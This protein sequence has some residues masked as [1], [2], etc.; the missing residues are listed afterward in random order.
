MDDHA[1]VEALRARDPQAPA[2]LYDAY[3]GGLYGYCWF[4]LCDRDAARAA[5]CEAFI[6]AEAHIGRLRTTGR[7]GP[8]LYAMARLECDRREAEGGPAQD[9]PVAVHD[10]D[11]VDQRILAWRAVR[12]MPPL[13]REVL[14]LRV[15]HQLP[16]PELGA[17]LG[18]PT[19]DA[20]RALARANADLQESLTAELLVK[21]GPYDCPGRAAILRERRGELT[22]PMRRWLLRHAQECEVCGKF[23]RRNVSPAKVYGLLP[24]AT[25]P[26]S[27]RDQVLSCFEAPERAGYRQEVA[28]RPVDFD[29]GFPVQQCAETPLPSDQQRPEEAEA[30]D[31]TDAPA[32]RSAGR[33]MAVVTVGSTCMVLLAAMLV[34]I[35]HDDDRVARNRAAPTTL[36][37][38]PREPAVVPE[39][40]DTEAWA[41][42]AVRGSSPTWPL[43]ATGS[44]APPTAQPTPPGRRG[45]E[46]GAPERPG[47][48]KGSGAL[49]VSPRYL[50]LGGGSSGSVELLAQG[51]PVA[52]RART[53][54]RIRL[55][56]TSGRL[57]K[58]RPV[59]LWL[60][61]V[62]RPGSSGQEVITFRPGGVRIVVTWRPVPRGEP[63][64]GPIRPSPPA[65]DGPSK[66]TPSVPPSRPG[67][68]PPSDPPPSGPPQQP[69]QPPADDP[70]PSDEP[71]ASGV[72]EPL[73]SSGPSPAPEPAQT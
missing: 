3:A 63:Q 5:L 65:P 73:P 16:V 25:L 38:V 53:S 47:A 4:R 46:P 44:T 6:M 54:G 59:T 32:G 35:L 49:E 20:Q 31:T 40:E 39:R 15:R 33:A 57:E 68:D 34:S 60:R 72:P 10:Q 55:S 62:R 28:A 7:L 58:G 41:I 9:P 17:V 23:R 70:P 11:D 29:G 48:P 64:P 51:G 43:G 19:R 52:W 22:A 24:E 56:R 30:A 42:D 36:S 14:E 66:D 12:G 71:P 13:S 61:V 21:E 69:T 8:W 27:L 18:L 37:P 50:D 67:Q 26:S 45:F 2:A 1:L